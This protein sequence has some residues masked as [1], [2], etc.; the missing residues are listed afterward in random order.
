MT[1]PAGIPA[2][3]IMSATIGRQKADATTDHSP[4]KR[5]PGT[6][7]RD[8]LMWSSAPTDSE[9][10]GASRRVDVVID[11]YGVLRDACFAVGAA[12]GRPQNDPP[13]M[14]HA[15]ANS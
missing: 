12:I 6:A 1:P 14:E 2:N 15:E 7:L 13:N 8:G 9:D 3:R 5:L 11:P 4:I 10:R